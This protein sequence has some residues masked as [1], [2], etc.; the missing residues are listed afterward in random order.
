M[1]VKTNELHVYIG[2]KIFP[3]IFNTNKISH[4]GEHEDKNITV[5]E[6]KIHL[7][8][9]RYNMIQDQSDLIKIKRDDEN[10]QVLRKLNYNV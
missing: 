1:K 3:K 4:S 8:L 10:S 5:Y 7:K 6:R 2:E 9:L